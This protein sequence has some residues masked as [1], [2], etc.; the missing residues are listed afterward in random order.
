MHVAC[1]HIH[2][3]NTDCVTF[4]I[5]ANPVQMPASFFKFRFPETGRKQ[6]LMPR[7]FGRFSTTP[8]RVR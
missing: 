7:G 4:H 1:V 8:G 3:V 5:N 2:V 6:D